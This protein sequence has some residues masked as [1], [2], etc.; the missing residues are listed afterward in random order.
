MNALMSIIS[1]FAVLRDLFRYRNTYKMNTGK[2]SG[3]HT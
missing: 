3:E 1:N 2:S